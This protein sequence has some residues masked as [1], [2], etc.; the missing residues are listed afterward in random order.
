MIELVERIK[1]EVER[2]EIDYVDADLSEQLIQLKI[3]EFLTEEVKREAI[4][5]NM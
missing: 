4:M 1:I 3:I 2:L 5:E